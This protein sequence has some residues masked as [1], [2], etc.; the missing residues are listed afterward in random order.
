LAVALDLE[1]AERHLMAVEGVTE[2]AGRLGEE[3]EA[4]LR[5][6]L[7]QGAPSPREKAGPDDVGREV[8]GGEDLGEDVVWQRAEAI[9]VRG[10]SSFTD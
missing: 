3:G 6:E 8:D 4:E 5:E 7:R 9:H 1:V 10:F 2:H